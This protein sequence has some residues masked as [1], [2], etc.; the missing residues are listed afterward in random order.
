M[1][2]LATG[3]AAIAALTTAAHAQ[4]L[5]IPDSTGDVVNIFSGADGSVVELGAF[6]INAA[7][8]LNQYTGSL[9]PIE[10]KQIGNEVWVTDQLADRVWRFDANTRQ[11][12]TAIGGFGDTPGQLNNVRGWEVVGNTAYFATGT[13]GAFT[14]GVISYDIPSNTF[15]GSTTGGLDTADISFFDV[16][17][18]GNELYVSN[19][20][21]GND[22]ILRFDLSLNLLGTFAASDGETSFDFAQQITVAASNGDIL[23]GGFSPPS[24]IYRFSPDGTPQGIVAGLDLGPRAGWELG[25]GQVIFSNGAGVQTDALGVIAAGSGRF[26]SPTSIPTPGAAATLAIAGLAASRRRR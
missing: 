3:A 21:S 8:A 13:D 9:T 1:P 4:N 11:P 19:I 15:L 16:Q 20:D 22:A 18:V 14:E 2:H 24:G 7:A 25:N 23:A 12:L 26:I 6:D 17:Q 5:L 10:A